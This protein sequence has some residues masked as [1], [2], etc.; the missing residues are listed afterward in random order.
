MTSV[1]KISAAIIA[2]NCTALITLPQLATAQDD[3]VLEEVL[4]TARKRQESLQQVPIAVTAFTENQIQRAGIERPR[5]F[6]ALTPNVTIVD[7]VN[8][9]DTQVTIRGQVSTRDAE[10]SFAYVVDGVLVT[11]PNGFNQEL[12]DVQQIEVLK[13]PQGALYGRNAVAGA[14]IVNTNRPDNE[15]EGSVK[16]GVGNNDLTKASAVISGPLIEDKL[17]GR[18]AGSYRDTEGEFKNR[19]T[20]KSGQ[21][22]YFEDTSLRGRL[23]WD[24]NDDWSLDGQ[25][26]YSEVKGGAVNFNASFA[27]PQATGANPD[28]YLDVND[29]EFQYIFNV[30]AEN[31]QETTAFSLKSDYNMGWATLT[32]ILAMDEVEEDLIS[33]GTS[34][35]FGGY[36]ALGGPES[37]AACTATGNDPALFD[38]QNS[39]SPFYNIQNGNPPGTPVDAVNAPNF[40][41]AFLPA[42]S[43]T[44]CDGYQYQERSQDSTS[45]ELK[46]TSGEDQALRWVGGLYYAQ[47]DREV[48]VAYGADLGLGFKAQ[49]YVAPDGP[50]PTDLLFWDEFDTEVTSIFGQ[51]EFDITE[52]QELA[53]ALRWDEEVREVSNKVPN[54]PN[55]QLG[56]V[57]PGP[58]PINPAFDGSYTDSIPDRK[59]TFDQLQPKVSWRWQA[60][61]DLSVYASYGVGFRSGGFNSLGSEA[62]VNGT[63]GTF[64]TAPQEI[65][66]DY[67]K[68]VSES[69][70]IGLKSDWLN[71]R[72]RVNAAVFHTE[73]EDN[74]FFNFY[75]GG[76]GLLRVVSNID[77][78][79]LQGYE[80][81]FQALI[82]QGLSFYGSYGY[83]DS[84]ID[85]NTNRPYTEGNK[86]PMAPESTANLGLQWIADLSDNMALVTRL[87]W[88]YLGETWFHSV[89]D[90]D[91]INSF[92]DLSA[93]YGPGWGFGISNYKKTKRDAYDTLNLRI[94]LEGTNWI[95]TAWGANITD[96]EYLEEVIPAPEFGGSFNHPAQ[97][98]TYGLDL[99][100]R[101]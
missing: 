94:S 21:V 63:F 18:L 26:S 22:D 15:V 41:N 9:G 90:N 36:A 72:L 95:V 73:I 25:L 48:V 98:S 56:Q 33:D 59:E 31:N 88:N 7:T 85:K 39:N 67:D 62:T 32:A 80:I 14:I 51:I 61:E 87:D 49:P 69:F 78:V 44:T 46:L 70:E 43:D 57:F 100:Y 29:Q 66:D 4:V 82:T 13:G 40:L 47:L 76:F 84:E 91:T 97:S 92:T 42:Y 89:Q 30:P 12:F 54:V 2:V 64:E 27:L 50:N 3:M 79:T 77:E 101:F 11:N 93:I 34:A 6:I 55:A 65:H 19:L 35:A 99:T 20:G 23:V 37:S 16:V 17:Y 24:V 60:M 81:D 83:V 8:V 5:D 75:A 38:L 1:K 52:N 53:F 71:Q 74:Q 28:F 45:I 58:A 96:E 68:E 10:S 86:A